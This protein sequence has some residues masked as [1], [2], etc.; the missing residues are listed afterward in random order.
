MVPKPLSVLLQVTALLKEKE[1]EIKHK[2]FCTDA[3]NTNEREQELK[4]RDIDELEAEIADLTSTIDE[5]TKAIN[6]LQSAR[7][8]ARM[9]AD[10]HL[11]FCFVFK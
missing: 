11:R 3:L 9:T 5:L 8:I 4:Q 1:D 2:D 10:S 6:T 7:Q